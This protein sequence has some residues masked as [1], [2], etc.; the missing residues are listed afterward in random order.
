MSDLLD[1]SEVDGA[2]IP[3]LSPT[4]AL[5]QSWW[6][7]GDD[8]SR[9]ALFMYYSTWL[10]KVTGNL[11]LRYHYPLAEWGDYIHLASLGLFSAIEKYQ[12]QQNTN[13]ESYAYLCVKGQI[14]NGLSN[15]T[16]ESKKVYNGTL[17]SN[18]IEE[19][20]EDSDPLSGVVSA[21]VGLALGY[22][23]ESGI[24]DE[25]IHE[26]DPLH[27]YQNEQES[28]LLKGL[29]NQLPEREQFVVIS[30][31]LHHINFKEIAEL[32]SI[33]TARVSQ[34]HNQA[35]KRLRKMYEESIDD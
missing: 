22:F 23:L 35:L 26:S 5:W 9:N 25:N 2:D 17:V 31:Y 18:R 28:G 11:M 29:V 10:R 4:P 21:V 16:S 12:P 6:Q 32:M 27:V 19:Y 3:L 30:H 7:L 24:H 15:Y 34:L 14:L 8:P 20:D 13:F 33:S 1:D